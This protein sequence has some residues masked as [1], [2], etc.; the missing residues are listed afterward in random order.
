MI[1][2][3]SNHGG[4]E[5]MKITI[6]LEVESM[7]KYFKIALDGPYVEDCEKFSSSKYNQYSKIRNI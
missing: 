1:K 5:I 4:L 6:N 3:Q 7:I 2:Y